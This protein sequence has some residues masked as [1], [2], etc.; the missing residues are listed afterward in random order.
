[1]GQGDGKPGDSLGPGNQQ[2]GEGKEKAG[3][4]EGEKA[5]EVDITLD[6]L[7]E[8]LGE[9]LELPRI[10]PKGNRSR[11]SPSATATPASARW[12]PTRCATSSAPTSRRSSADRLGALQPR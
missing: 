2:P 3:E 8:I 11:S 5:L 12:A 1:V 10:E 9:E 6:E 4:G 7:A